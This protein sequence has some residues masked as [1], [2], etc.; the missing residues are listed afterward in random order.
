MNVKIKSM[1][2]LFL[3]RI[4]E[5]CIVHSGRTKPHRQKKNFTT[6]LFSRYGWL[7]GGKIKFL[8][9][10]HHTGEG[11]GLVRRCYHIHLTCC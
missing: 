10:P 11:N 7:I 5:I 8:P 3:L 1:S 9:E 6:F 4:S 2:L